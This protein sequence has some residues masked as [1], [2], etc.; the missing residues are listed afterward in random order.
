MPDEPKW[1]RLTQVWIAIL[2]GLFAFI[3]V[4]C[5]PPV[6]LPRLIENTDANQEPEKD[7]QTRLQLQE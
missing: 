1:R 4:L 7:R 2:F 3:C 6:T 5:Y